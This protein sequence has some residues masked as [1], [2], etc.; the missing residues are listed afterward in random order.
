[1]R[2]WLRLHL[3]YIWSE[4]GLIIGLV[5]ENVTLLGEIFGEEDFVKEEL[6]KINKAIEEL[7]KKV[8]ESGKNALIVM[9]TMAP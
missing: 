5:T 2:N 6:E 7:N 9:L 4:M 1:M 3:P 8:T